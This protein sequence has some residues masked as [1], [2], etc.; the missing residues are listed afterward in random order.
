MTEEKNKLPSHLKQPMDAIFADIPQQIT[1]HLQEI[2]ATHLW[3]KNNA[4][5]LETLKIFK[6]IVRQAK[7]KKNISNI[8]F[9]DNMIAVI[10]NLLGLQL[11]ENIINRLMSSVY[12]KNL[13]YYNIEQKISAL[14]NISI[15][16]W[17]W[18]HNQDMKSQLSR[19][20][21]WS[22]AELSTALYDK[23]IQEK[24]LQEIEN[25]TGK[26]VT[27]HIHSGKSLTH[28]TKNANHIFLVLTIGEKKIILDP[29]FGIMS[30]YEKSGYSI[31]SS[32][33]EW[34]I[35]EHKKVMTIGSLNIS[36]NG[37]K[38]DWMYGDSD[39]IPL[40]MLPNNNIYIELAFL[41][42]NNANVI[43]VFCSVDDQGCTWLYF[44]DHG[45]LHFIDYTTKKLQ[46]QKNITGPLVS[47]ITRAF[48]KI[49]RSN[50][51]IHGNK[52]DFD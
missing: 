24:T 5:Y 26:N 50:D 38:W 36:W 1:E 32:P 52:Y 11:D 16:G 44:M 40:W 29:S 47:E 48:N 14:W 15:L 28:F 18:I 35:R 20:I 13:H 34:N 8:S 23:L 9:A 33:I 51:M 6:D 42:M 41:R 45:N 22:C 4:K 37:E 31:E 46:T 30:A 49:S 39:Y 25:T 12:D 19:G 3:N 2:F 27:L 7:N 21:G 10:K 17:S 43:P